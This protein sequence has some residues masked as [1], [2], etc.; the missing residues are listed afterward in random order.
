M[1]VWGL[2]RELLSSFNTV[3]VM[4]GVMLLSMVAGVVGCFMV[5]RKRALMADATSHAT[6]PGIALAFLILPIFGFEGKAL[7]GLLI[8]ALLT[9]LC[10]MGSILI[11]QKFT[12]LKEDVAMG[13]V[14]SVYYGFGIVLLSVISQMEQLGSPAGLE[15]YIFGKTAAM[16]T[17]DAALIAICALVVL[18]LVLALY[19]EFK[20]ICFD[21]DY[22]AS[23]A[24]PRAFLDSLLMGSVV[25]ITVIGLQAVGLILM[26][27]LLVVPPAAAKFWT[28]RLGPM[29]FISAFLGMV[30]GCVGTLIS[31]S[32]PDA[33]AGAVI[34]LCQGVCFLFSMLFGIRDGVVKKAV[35]ARNLRRRVLEHHLLRSVWEAIEEREMSPSPEASLMT[36]AEWCGLRGWSEHRLRMVL[37]GMLIRGEVYRHPDGRVGL[38]ARGINR[39]QRIVRNHRLWEV[40]LVH[41]ADVATT[42]VDRMADR[43]EHV[44]DPEL[45][46]KLE[47]Q[48]DAHNSAV[49]PR[50]PHPLASAGGEG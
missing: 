49:L 33:P 24:W 20:L 48:L 42:Q 45:I 1:I 3:M 9:G 28:N 5:L 15:S 23:L 7:P 4:T 10:G 44:L 46:D 50:S 35:L 17:K 19:K 16:I 13:I 21:S 8:G 34:V 22:V 37:F 25:G 29:L 31:A 40:F 2:V 18:L 12:R 27:A 41:N 47:A 32:V 30:S 26:I 6:L 36:R 38:T 14:L 43:I 11:I 39:A